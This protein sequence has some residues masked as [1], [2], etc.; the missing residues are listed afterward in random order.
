MP[1]QEQCVAP[2]Q[3]ANPA[4]D[5]G[6]CR[7]LPCEVW[8]QCLAQGMAATR[9]VVL[10]GAGATPRVRAQGHLMLLQAVC[11]E[12]TEGMSCLAAENRCPSGTAQSPVPNTVS[13]LETPCHCQCSN[14]LKQSVPKKIPAFSGYPSLLVPIPSITLILNPTRSSAIPPSRASCS[15]MDFRPKGFSA[16]VDTDQH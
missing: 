7:C 6:E 16:A 10:H 4:N 11:P 1:A 5:R 12:A 13:V 14:T 3:G 8:L 9:M 2:D 15:R